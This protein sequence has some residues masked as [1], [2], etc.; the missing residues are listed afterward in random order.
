MFSLDK[1]VQVVAHL[2]KALKSLLLASA[3]EKKAYLASLA[4]LAN[5]LQLPN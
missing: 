4:F 3:W 2:K 1:N 5:A